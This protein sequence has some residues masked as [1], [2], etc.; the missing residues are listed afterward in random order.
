MARRYL[1]VLLVVAALPW[2]A[3]AGGGP[4]NVLVIVNDNSPESLEIGQYYQE[5]RGL[6]ERHLVHVQVTTNYTTDLATFTNQVVNPVRDYLANSGL[7]NQ[8]DYLVLTL[9]MPYRVREGA[10]DN[11]AGSVLFYGFKEEGPPCSLTNAARSDYYASETT[12]TRASTP[13]SNRYYSST[14]L[15]GFTMDQARRTLDRAKASD[16][17]APTGRVVLLHTTDFPRTIR[18]SQF[19]EAR[20]LG[21]FGHP[22]RKWEEYTLNGLTAASNILGYL[23][24]VH[25]EPGVNTLGFVP[26][27][28]ADHLTSFGGYLFDSDWQMSILAYLAAGAAGSYGTVVEPCPF[29]QK[30][31]QARVHY[32]Y[33]RGFN[34]AESYTM[35]VEYP[36]QGVFVGD[37]LTAPYAIPPQVTVSGLVA[38]TA[39]TSEVALSFSA[40]T[41]SAAGRISKLD[42]FVDGLFAG[43]A[44]NHSPTPGHTVSAT[45][46]GT[47]RTYTVL[48][49]DTLEEVAAGL[50]GEI[51]DTPPLPYT[52]TAR[53]DRVQIVQDTLGAS[54][55]W[56]Q[57]SASA[58][59]DS[60][61]AR[62]VF[63]NFQESP[64]YAKE[65]LVLEGAPVSGDV[66]RVVIT[67]TDGVVVTN[68]AIAGTN[69][70][71]LSLL[72]D[73]RTA[74]NG[75]W[76][77]GELTGCKM[78]WVSGLV[79]SNMEAWLVARTNGWRGHNL[80]VTY[81][82]VTNLG[83]SLDTSSA[84]S[85]NFNDNSSTLSA[86]AQ[87]F[88]TDGSTNLQAS[89]TLGL[90]NL[91]DGP[92]ELEV[93]AYEGSAV[94]VQ[95]RTR[96]P[97]TVKTHDLTCAITN[98]VNGRHVLRGASITAEV[99]VASPGTVT[100]VQ[101]WT[102]G[103]LFAST[104]APPYAFPWPTTNY[105]A[106]AIGLQALAHDDG[107]R[108][109]LSEVVTVQLYTD[110]DGDGL[111]D[112]WEYRTLG[113]R[114]NGAAGDDPDVDGQNNL[115]E[116]LA[117]TDPRVFDSRHEI[118]GLDL[119]NG[120]AL[121][122]P[123]T[124]TRAFA[125]EI[126]GDLLTSNAWT[127]ATN[128]VPSTNGLAQW[129]DEATNGVRFYRVRAGL[130]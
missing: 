128:P 107:G 2:F 124:N 54:G 109:T 6:P 73:L 17:S 46:A 115:A 123:V 21:Q 36:H 1:T 94:R 119:T 92:H 120:L 77:L 19:D 90:T 32:W 81:S 129:P 70:T 99:A 95:G 48:T 71:C 105:G 68:Q 10:T 121:I 52:A 126:A 33:G 30:F 15:S 96:I 63:T 51:N 28:L 41:T 7:S 55:A 14:V 57:V 9:G 4:H 3:R 122:F 40:S 45:I 72:L 24:G 18:W 97:F 12:F 102:E 44:T 106:G 118:S 69:S 76:Q 78:E 56:I 13:S 130:P 49:G 84:F 5:L 61:D 47:T 125:V 101:F 74:V 60:V 108:A 11:G 82:I 53:G 8:V 117:D 27:S 64:I 39:V 116:F 86:R 29:P 23:N 42:V 43:T 26:G 16:Q 66:V 37:P 50:A 88:L 114:T 31:P 75:N 20:F 62:S 100:Q 93:V 113:S 85:D 127:T 112:Q 58:S 67:R 38:N 110:T 22:G 25:T 80:S 104:S 91:P 65:G 59:G 35:A 34:L 89:W 111:S 98:L 87:I 103:K 79:V 83:S